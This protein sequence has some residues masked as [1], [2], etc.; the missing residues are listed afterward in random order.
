VLVDGKAQVVMNDSVVDLHVGQAYRAK[1]PVVGSSHS[2]PDHNA[3]GPQ[4]D[5]KT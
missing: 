3:G 5:S 1:E 4:S 2:Q